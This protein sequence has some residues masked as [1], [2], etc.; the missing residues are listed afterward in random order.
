MRIMKPSEEKGGGVNIE[1]AMI[2]VPYTGWTNN[3]AAGRYEIAIDLTK[4]F[5]NIGENDILVATKSY[6][7]LSLDPSGWIGYKDLTPYLII[8]DTRRRYSNYLLLATQSNPES[9]SSGARFFS[10]R[11]LL[12]RQP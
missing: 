11:L 8:D 2:E 5:Q 6:D 3:E 10:L 9:S 12:F 4:S 7:T 1:S